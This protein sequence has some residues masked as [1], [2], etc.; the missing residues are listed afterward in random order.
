MK[1]IFLAIALTA[2]V[3][4]PANHLVAQE[5]PSTQDEAGGTKQQ[6]ASAKRNAKMAKTRARKERQLERR[7]KRIQSRETRKAMKEGPYRNL[8]ELSSKNSTSLTQKEINKIFESHK[9]GKFLLYER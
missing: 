9:S 3:A 5:E 4:L 1:N 6:Q 8:Q 2:L 7:H